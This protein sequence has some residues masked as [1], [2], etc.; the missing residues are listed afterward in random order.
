MYKGKKQKVKIDRDY[1]Y[2]ELE[3]IADDMGLPLQYVFN[4]FCFVLG[5]EFE[6]SEF[7]MLV[8]DKIEQANSKDREDIPF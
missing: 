2:Y 3:A 6:L 7:L 1:L 4:Q 8:V 5:T